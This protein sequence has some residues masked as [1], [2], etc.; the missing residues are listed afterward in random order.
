MSLPFPASKSLPLLRS[1]HPLSMSLSPRQFQDFA[2]VLDGLITMDNQIDL[3]EWSM[4]KVIFNHLNLR[5]NHNLHGSSK[6]HQNLPE[7]TRFLG[8]L[9]HYGGESNQ[10]K[11]S[12]EKGAKVL[13]PQ[14]QISLPS[15]QDCGIAELE[16]ALIKIQKLSASEKRIFLTACM[17][18]AEHDGVI[19]KTNI[20]Y[21]VDWPPPSPAHS[22]LFLGKLP[23]VKSGNFDFFISVFSRL[24]TSHHYLLGEQGDFRPM[25]IRSAIKHKF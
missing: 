20:R 13:T 17:A 4:E 25:W 18:I 15:I 16:D 3:F 21:F 6:I 5:K 12:F 23:T 8:A 22:D 19:R 2:Q 9:S 24:H 10:A 11:D 1:V 14:N 7:C